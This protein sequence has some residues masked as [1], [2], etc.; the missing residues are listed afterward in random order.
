MIENYSPIVRIKVLGI[1]GGGNNSV[2]RMLEEDLRLDGVEFVSLNTDKAVLMRNR[3]ETKICIGERLTKGQGAGS[4]P[5]IGQRAAE[6]S[7]EDIRAI[8]EGTDLVFITAGMG[9]GTGTGAS[10]VV[11]AVARELGIL[12]VA[13]VTKPFDFEGAHKMLNAEIGIK[14]LSKF[15]D[16]TIVVPNQRLVEKLKPKTGMKEAFKIADEILRQGVL[17]LAELIVNPMLINLDF[18]DI[19]NVLRSSG[20]AHIGIGRAKGDNRLLTAVKQAVS[21][22]LL[23]T[24]ING[25]TKIIMSVKGG[26][27]LDFHEVST[28]GTLV[29]DVVD[30]GCNIIFG[31]DMSPELS[32]EVQVM[33]VATGLP[34]DDSAVLKPAAA[35]AV[36]NSAE[37]IQPPLPPE[38]K[39]E[40][41]EISTVK[42]VPPF[43][44]NFKNF[45]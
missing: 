1:G 24:C 37:P 5:E 19:S 3:A 8:L 38:I 4:N 7:R 39:A 43:F 31:A 20:V 40:K 42:T 29:R 21:S 44:R 22:P 9:G 10:P 6:E 26:D 41:P 16:A 27:D 15:V 23:E 36:P 25:A 30:P 33:I 17:G 34:S 13:V 35:P 18:A 32:G 14:N 45:K 28:C 11:A 12:S 2:D